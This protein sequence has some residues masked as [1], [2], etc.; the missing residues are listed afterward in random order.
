[1]DRDQ[2]ALPQVGEQDPDHA[3]RKIEIGGEIS[4]RGREAAPPQQREV[5]GLE[6]VHV[7]RGPANRGDHRYQVEG[8][9]G[10]AGPAADQRVGTDNGPGVLIKPPIICRGHAASLRFCARGNRPRVD[11]HVLPDPR[12][13]NGHLVGDESRVS[14]GGGQDGQAATFARGRYEQEL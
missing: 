12:D 1:M 2:P 14:G 9:A 8:L 7:G 5:L 3:D 6:T 13:Q 10:R 4:H 11:G